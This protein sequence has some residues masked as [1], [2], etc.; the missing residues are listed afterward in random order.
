MN[1]LPLHKERGAAALEYILISTFAVAFSL[2]ALAVLT[3]L[4]KDELGRLSA[5]L[6][7]TLDTSPIDGL[8]DGS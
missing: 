2:A 3:H 1:A 5:R 4:V 8:G 7:I 6:G